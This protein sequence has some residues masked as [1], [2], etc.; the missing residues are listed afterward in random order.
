MS[1]ETTGRLRVL[2]STQM[3]AQL[4]DGLPVDVRGGHTTVE[5][6]S[7][8]EL[9]TAQ[10]FLRRLLDSA[11]VPFRQQAGKEGE[12]IQRPTDLRPDD[13]VMV[14]PPMAGGSR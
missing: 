10:A 5:F 6:K 7:A 2:G 1:S 11:Y 3:I 14:I 4:A 8:E 9:E 13:D 12:K